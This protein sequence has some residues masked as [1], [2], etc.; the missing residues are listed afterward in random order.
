ML[1]NQ[2]FWE[3]EIFGNFFE[4]RVLKAID[5]SCRAFKKTLKVFHILS[6]RWHQSRKSFLLLVTTVLIIF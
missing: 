5:G 3:K 6:A 4:Y 2:D 1:E